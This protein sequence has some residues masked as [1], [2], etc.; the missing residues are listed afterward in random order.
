MKNLRN[1]FGTC[2]RNLLHSKLS[3]ELNNKIADEPIYEELDNILYI[4]IHSQ[5]DDNL[6]EEMDSILFAKAPD[7][8]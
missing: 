3:V 6:Y 5:V 4:I 8:I 1:D 7:N 2:L